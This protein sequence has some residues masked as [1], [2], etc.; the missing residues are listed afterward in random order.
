[1]GYATQG[2]HTDVACLRVEAAAARGERA[3]VPLSKLCF[4]REKCALVSRKVC[5]ASARFFRADA[6]STADSRRQTTSV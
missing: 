4:T 3:P 2:L 1:M 6:G 5:R